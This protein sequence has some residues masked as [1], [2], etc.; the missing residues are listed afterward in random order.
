MSM[1]GLRRGAQNIN[2]RGGKGAS[3]S[4]F[5]ARW[6]PP[7]IVATAGMGQSQVKMD[8]RPF[9]AA[10]PN[11]ESRTEVSEPIVLVAGQYEDV[12]AIDK[13]GNRITPP[14]VTEGFRFKVHTFNVFVKPK[15]PGQTGFS[16]FRDIICSAGPEPHAPQ[17]CVG[18]Y[19]HDHGQKDAKPKDQWAFN[20]AHLG[21]YHLEPLVKDGQVQMKKDNSGPVM[22][23]K[24][25]LSYKMENVVMG[26]AVTAGR[27][28]N[29]QLAK[30][31]KQ[32]EGCAQQHQYVFGEHR[33]LQLGY[34]HLKNLLA[35][36]DLIGKRCLSCGTNIMRMAFDCTKCNNE[37]VNLANSGWTNDQIEQFSKTA[38]NCPHC[39]N[40]DVPYSVYEC[41]FDDNYTRVR[42]S[43]EDPV[44]TTVFH[45]VL[46]VQREGEK[47][48][49]E[50]VVKKIEL[51]PQYKTH[52][53]RALSEHLKEIVKEPFNLPDMY[54]PESL[55]EQAQLLDVPNPYVSQQQQYTTYP[56]QPG[57][58]YGV[59]QPGPG[60]PGAGY[61]TAQTGPVP[62]GQ[63]AFPQ[64]P[65]PGR[66]NFGK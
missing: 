9:L 31:Y 4:A 34:G 65:M 51:I 5:Y 50:L 41:G 45:C 18:D 44:K 53:N 48:D 38:T 26:R 59:Q 7:S 21:W 16:S 28:P 12:Y 30:K 10:P 15:K 33:V 35:V 13:D 1:D 23:K 54:K 49:S 3:R 25:C 58:G 19:L 17:P 22:V 62:G 11:E 37:M 39:G 6:K 66:P 57:P 52:D 32:C 8:L 36:D 40:F 60:V 20:I 24:E 2:P 47:T 55:D 56:G 42:E 29:A 64:M 61:S 43:C 63:P 27:V 46:W 14:P